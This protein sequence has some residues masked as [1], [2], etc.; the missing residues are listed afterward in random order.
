MVLER[1]TPA[2]YDMA[3][4][5]AGATLPRSVARAGARFPPYYHVVWEQTT[6]PYRYQRVNHYLAHA[7]MNE[8]DTGC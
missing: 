3:A 8:K 4:G 5:G 1:G 2:Q 7:E 6:H